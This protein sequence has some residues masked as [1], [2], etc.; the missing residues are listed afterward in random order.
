M[1]KAA[2]QG[3]APF[4]VIA[5]TPP[6]DVAVAP[7]SPEPA[8]SVFG[9]AADAPM[10][11]AI[12]ASTDGAPPSATVR[13]MGGSR[14]ATVLRRGLAFSIAASEACRIDGRASLSVPVAKSLGLPAIVARRSTSLAGHGSSALVLHLSQRARE[15]LRRQRTASLR[16]ALTLTDR[17]GNRSFL[18]RTVRLRR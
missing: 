9:L 14:L 16:V 2:D 5:P 17:A 3:P 13:L 8:Q 6:P 11:P 1:I 4:E 10:L 15:R 12:V 18:L 7:S